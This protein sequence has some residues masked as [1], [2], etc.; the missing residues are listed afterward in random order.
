MAPSTETA[1]G[2]SRA[3]FG[4]F[5]L[6]FSIVVFS[7]QDT[8]TKHL[9]LRYPVPF[10]LMIR[11][12]VFAIFAAALASRQV[13][14]VITASRSRRP[15][16]QIL[17]ALILVSEM[18]VFAWS[19]QYLKLA[20]AHSI[21]AVY[22]LMTTVLAVWI[23]GEKIGWRRWVAVFVGFAGV[24]IILRPGLSVFHPAAI[25]PFI[26]AIA[27]ALYAIL[28]R[29]VSRSD[30]F[31]TTFLYTG[32]FGAIAISFVGPFYTADPTMTDW[33]WIGV[34]C[35]TGI[36]G[37][38][39]LIKALEYTPAAKLQPFNYLIIVG[40]TIMGYLAF[41]EIPDRYTMIGAAIIV[42]SGLF[43]VWRERV[44]A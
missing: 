37:H 8:I 2:Q 21:F 20:D 19:L 44:R 17:R 42:S 34:L 31:P 9:A 24:L 28:T 26:G 16:L 39:L 1:S 33:G 3:M 35:L 40:A 7:I 32:I 22:P 11:Y 15:I 27:F 41:A 5:L 43:V 38:F 23:L 14:S 13:G 6:L 25:V 30:P 36:A 10:F 18:G 12:W 4:I 29:L